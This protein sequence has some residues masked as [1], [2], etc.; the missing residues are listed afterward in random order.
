MGHPQSLGFAL[1]YPV[2]NRGLVQRGQLRV[3]GRG[4]H[5]G[6]RP[7]GLPGRPAQQAGRNPRAGGE[8]DQQAGVSPCCGAAL[9]GPAERDTELGA[10]TTAY[11][12]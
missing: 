12:V 5:G 7:Q 2:G 9:A 3:T 8:D 10:V 4:E 1:Y 6:R 11:W